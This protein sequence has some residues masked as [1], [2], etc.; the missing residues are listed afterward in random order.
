[1]LPELVLLISLTAMFMVLAVHID[2]LTMYLVMK[3]MS[4]EYGMSSRRNRR[5]ARDWCTIYDDCIAFRVMYYW[6]M[7]A[8]ALIIY[9]YFTDTPVV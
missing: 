7:F 9:S 8:W 6:G 3:R 4:I 1:M 2:E 5:I